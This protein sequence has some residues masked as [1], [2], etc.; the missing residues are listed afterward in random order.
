MPPA[1][2]EGSGWTDVLHADDKAVTIERWTHSIAT[3]EPYEVEYR[4]RRADGAWRWHLGRGRRVCDEDGQIIRWI[5]TCTDIHDLKEAEAGLT[6]LARELGH[7]I[8][9]LFAVAGAILTMGARQEGP[10]V[11]RF[12]ATTAARLDALARIQDHV[13]PGL[14]GDI[15]RAAY[16]TLHSLVDALAEPHVGGSTDRVRLTGDDLVLSD[17]SNS[18]FALILHELFTNALKHGALSTPGGRVYIDTEVCDEE[19]HMRWRELDGPAVAGPPGTI[20]FGTTLS[21]RIVRSQLRGTIIRHWHGGGLE[22]DIA[23]PR[24]RLQD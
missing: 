9:N 12:A 18:A 10:D 16:P 11:R 7:R 2:S 5:G 17:R 6:L 1:H 15:R 24:A 3:G 23:V 8:K 4:L 13:R 19:A 14:A 21:D 20:G 22:V